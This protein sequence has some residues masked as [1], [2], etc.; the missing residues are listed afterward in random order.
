MNK[1]L[2]PLKPNH[3]LPTKLIQKPYLKKKKSP[4]FPFSYHLTRFYTQNDWSYDKTTEFWYGADINSTYDLS[5]QVLI[6]RIY[7]FTH[8]INYEIQL[9]DH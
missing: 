1:S 2:I 9:A 6:L 3:S 5:K 7:F 4:T 8:K